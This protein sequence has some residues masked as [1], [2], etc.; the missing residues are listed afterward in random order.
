[1]KLNFI[2]KTHDD[3]N[4]NIL[5]LYLGNSMTLSNFHLQQLEMPWGMIHK[6]WRLK[7]NYKIRYLTYM[8]HSGI[9]KSEH[10]DE[11]GLFVLL[12]KAI[13]VWDSHCGLFYV[14][15]PRIGYLEYDV[16][17]KSQALW[18]YLNIIMKNKSKKLSQFNNSCK[19]YL[20]HQ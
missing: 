15:R 1:M 19:N 8:P 13:A 16:S 17:Q 6:F 5:Q 10:M 11:K 7:S 3:V 2:V 18:K 9:W 4:D 14:D 12:Q 20:P